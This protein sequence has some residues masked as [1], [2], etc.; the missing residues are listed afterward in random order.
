MLLRYVGPPP[1]RSQWERE[2]GAA[3]HIA[4]DTL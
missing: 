4:W 3:A 1:K 2:P